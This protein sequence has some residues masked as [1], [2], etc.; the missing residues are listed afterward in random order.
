MELRQLR[1]FV[2]VAEELNFNRAAERLLLAQPALSQQIRNLEHELS[3]TLFDRSR[4]QI[5]LTV[6]GRALLTEA[7]R[8]LADVENAVRVTQR[9]E[10]GE[11]GCLVIGVTPIASW[12]LPTVVHRYQERFPEVEI[13]VEE[14]LSVQ[15]IQAL[16]KQHI[17]VAFVLSAPDEEDLRWQ[18][19]SSVP[20]LIALPTQHPLAIRNVPY[21]QWKD[22]TAYSFVMFPRRIQM[23]LFDQFISRCQSAGYSPTIAR[24]VAQIE[25]ILNM[26]SMNV[27]I[28]PVPAYLQK[29]VQWQGVT[30][31]A[32][33]PPVP[34]F[35]IFVAW[36]GDDTSPVLQNFLREVE[37]SEGNR[38]NE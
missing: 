20:S 7:Y 38:Y 14:L 29:M 10:R 21:L 17:D 30:F 9:A 37:T 34:T 35:E 36:R 5:G 32:L 25:T 23:R 1:Y 6:A 24:E 16:Q 22:L 15:Q 8:I 19:L 13:E 33:E 2:T 18:L 3:V 26:V 4:R 27:G 31:R 28:A 11:T 12:L